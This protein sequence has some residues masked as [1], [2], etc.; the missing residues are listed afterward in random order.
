MKNRFKAGIKSAAIAAIFATMSV[1]ASSS[2]I[3]A[4]GV[5]PEVLND[6]QAIFMTFDWHANGRKQATEKLFL[7]G[8]SKKTIRGSWASNGN[9]A[10][11]CSISGAGQRARC[12]TR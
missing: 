10:Y 8:G 1:T 3:A 7:T 11:V 5:A 4:A 12:Y 9:G 2:Q 6:D